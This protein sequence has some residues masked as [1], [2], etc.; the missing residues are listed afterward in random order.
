MRFH[1]N[2]FEMYYKKKG[3]NY[4]YNPLQNKVIKNLN[5]KLSNIMKYNDIP[6]KNASMVTCN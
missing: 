4:V 5:F 2:N 1:L 3:S 6:N